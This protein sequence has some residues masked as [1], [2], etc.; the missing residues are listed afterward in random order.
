MASN[1]FY[2]IFDQHCFIKYTYGVVC[3]WWSSRMSDVLAISGKKYKISG[4]QC[5]KNQDTIF[6]AM[7]L[8]RIQNI[9]IIQFLPKFFYF[10]MIN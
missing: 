7:Y 6:Y 5:Y 3:Q 10:K 9:S 4:M 8:G 1:L 2:A